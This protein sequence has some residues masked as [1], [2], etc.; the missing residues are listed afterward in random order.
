MSGKEFLEEA[1]ESI[2]E[3]LKS[4]F[5]ITFIISWIAWNWLLIYD[6]FNFP[7]TFSLSEKTNI[8]NQYIQAHIWDNITWRPIWSALISSLVFV[9]GSSVFLIV[10]NL[11]NTTIKSGIFKLTAKGENIPRSLY[12]N[13]NKRHNRLKVSFDEATKLWTDL[14]NENSTLKEENS[15]LRGSVSSSV[16]QLKQLS[17]QKKKDDE[18]ISTL[19]A[20]IGN[21]NAINIINANNVQQILMNKKLWYVSTS[22]LHTPEKSG[23]LTLRFNNNNIVTNENGETLYQLANMKTSNDSVVVMFDLLDVKDLDNI[24]SVYLVNRGNNSFGGIHKAANGSRE[25][26][27]YDTKMPTPNNDI[28]DPF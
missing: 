2:N 27:T 17:E 14:E 12:N 13:L 23:I 18:K 16:T 24:T 6:V 25:I 19:H 11:Y 21:L 20:Q 7:A 28:D 5:I 1:K 8:I 10:F 4:P 3:R 15:S 26:V 22:P 9:A